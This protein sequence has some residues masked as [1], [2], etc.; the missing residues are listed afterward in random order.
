MI[1]QLLVCG[2]LLIP[3]LAVAQPAPNRQGEVSSLVA[4][5]RALLDGSDDKGRIVTGL[6]CNDLNVVDNGQWGMLIKNDR[7]PP[8]VPYDILVWKPTREHIDILSGFNPMWIDNGLIRPEWSWL[9][10]P[11]S[12]PAPP[13]VVVPPVVVVPPPVVLPPPVTGPSI[14]AQLDALKLTTD[15]T[16]VQIKEH[17]AAVQAVWLKIAAIAGPAMSAI[18]TYLGTH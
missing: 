6:I 16:L 5:Y 11:T 15:E 7:N 14:Q 8:F 18:L 3:S 9:V 1:R 10:C 17:R 12:A 13:P 4:K 2:L